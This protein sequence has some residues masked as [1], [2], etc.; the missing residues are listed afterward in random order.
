[1]MKYLK[2]GEGGD[3]LCVLFCPRCPLD[4]LVS[5]A[6]VGDASTWP[7][8]KEIHAE[9]PADKPGASLVRHQLPKTAAWSRMLLVA[10]DT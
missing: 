1:M 8:G 5:Q 3:S 9:D 6:E 2:V 7:T 4:D 10:A